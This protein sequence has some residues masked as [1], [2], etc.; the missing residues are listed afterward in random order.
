[1]KHL[2]YFVLGF[3]IGIPLIA[4]VG[5]IAGAVIIFL[6]FAALSRK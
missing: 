2:L 5:P 3:L 1:M 4:V 6:L